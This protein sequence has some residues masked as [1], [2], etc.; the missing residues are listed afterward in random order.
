[1]GVWHLA[2]L[3]VNPGA[4]TAPLTYIYLLLKQSL[5]GDSK[6]KE[7]FRYS[8]EA[9]EA[10]P[11]KPE[12]LIIFTSEA[13]IRG[14]AQGN[15]VEDR[16]FKTEK[17][18]SALETI[19]AYLKRLLEELENQKFRKFYQEKW[20][21]Y[22]YSISVNHEDFEDCFRKIAIT[23][24]A[25][26]DKEIWINMV[27]GTNQINSALLSSSGLTSAAGTYYYVFQTNTS[28]LHPDI[29]KPDFDNL[30]I[31]VPP[32][33]WH[34]LPY[35]SLD[36]SQLYN[37]L[38]EVFSNR[39]KVNINEIKGILK[40]LNFPEQFLAKLRGSFLKINNQIV[41]KG[42]MLDYWLGLW[43]KL[44]DDFKK[45]NNFTTWKDWAEKNRIFKDIGAF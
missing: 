8:G 40:E 14:E 35:F 32:P 19:K 17:K 12:A 6:A 33:S 27:G 22:F 10:L 18:R 39:D 45:V 2:G 28:L 11:G 31:A 29:E 5:L 16:W 4:V 42:A 15:K 38:K 23:I 20:I 25:L 30:R 1:M 34:E 37:R 9:R 41:M 21:K 7:F 36:M 44:Q 24:N 13:V 43:N 3:G 26:K